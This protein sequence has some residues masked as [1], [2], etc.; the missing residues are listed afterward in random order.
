MSEATQAEI[1][2]QNN[3]SKN[4]AC[5]PPPQNVANLMPGDA[6]AGL[7]GGLLDRHLTLLGGIHLPTLD[8]RTDPRRAVDNR[9]RRRSI[10]K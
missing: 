3:E 4:N 6:G 8:V 1:N 2:A 7:I 10:I 5:K 9:S